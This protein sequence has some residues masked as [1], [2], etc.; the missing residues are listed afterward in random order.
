MTDTKT[1]CSKQLNVVKA[2]AKKSMEALGR[3]NNP[4]SNEIKDKILKVQAWH[5]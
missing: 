4:I 3:I 2:D 5:H 1:E